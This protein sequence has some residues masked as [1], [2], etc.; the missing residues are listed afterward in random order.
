MNTVSQLAALLADRYRI[1]RELGSGGMATVFLATELKHSR[2]VAIKVLKPEIAVALGPERFLREIRIAAQLDHPHIL[3]LIDSGSADGTLYYVLP[4]VRGESLRQKLDREHHLELNDALRVTR[5]V[6][7]ALDYAHRA[8]IIHRDIKPENILL[9]EGEA[10]LTDFGIALAVREAGGSRLTETGASLGTPQYMSP[11][12][13]SGERE[14]D[15]RSDEYSLAAVLYEML[16][17]EPPH[18]GASPRAVI[19]KILTE[20]PTSL[21]VLRDTVPEGVDRAVAKALAK[22]P[23]DRYPDVAGFVG[24]LDARVAAPARGRGARAR[25]VG[26]AAA[27]IA[28]GIAL[29]A[30]WVRRQRPSPQPTQPVYDR[31]QVTTSGHATDPTVSSDGSEVAYLEQTCADDGACR[32]AL[33]VRDLASGAERSLVDNI[34]WGFPTAFTP[35]G[36]WLLVNGVAVADGRPA[37]QYVVSRLGGP[38]VFVG[39]GRGDL[40]PS[41]DSVLI[42]SANDSGTTVRFRVIG[43]PVTQPADT[44]R[45]ASRGTFGEIDNARVAPDGRWVAVLW[46]RWA[47]NDIVAL[48]DRQGVLRDTTRVPASTAFSL[49]WAPTGHAVLAYVTAQSGEGSLLRIAVDSSGRFGNR[50]TLIV[51]PGQRGASEFATAPKA[52]DLAY[53]LVQPGEDLLWRLERRESGPPRLAKRVR[54]SSLP[55]RAVLVKDGRTLVFDA[56][57]PGSGGSRDEFFAQAFDSG[58]ARPITPPLPGVLAWSPT[59]DGRRLVVETAGKGAGVRLTAYDI[60]SGRAVPFAELGAMGLLSESGRDGIA[61]LD[62]ASGTLHLFDGAGRERAAIA[63]PDSLGYAYTITS[64]PDATAWAFLA[65]RPDTESGESAARQAIYRIDAQTKTPRRITWFDFG[66]EILDPFAWTSDGSIYFGA[67]AAFASRPML[68]RVAA[69]GGTATAASTLPF[70]P[71]RCHCAISSDGK[72]WVGAVSHPISDIF[73]LRDVDLDRR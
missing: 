21:R 6:G 57:V 35:D 31:V 39:P 15:A 4:Y 22:V 13:A 59:L 69:S 30:M 36:A 55:L 38:L 64:S 10:V 65:I 23:A 53:Q 49:R 56:A 48:Y 32:R 42:A 26:V 46:E 71:D 40:V 73:L 41:G 25:R 34:G 44:A 17:G 3:T 51:T 66:N 16:A 27:S 60:P 20:R 63:I 8:G 70:E 9:Q 54:S 45:A 1:E 43:L 50:D 12:Q 18:T 29:V 28:L 14:L 24:A 67:L 58:D 7:A 37:G 72:R 11:E 19:A 62:P 5:Q 52:R 68:W 47:G 2:A 33:M 61:L